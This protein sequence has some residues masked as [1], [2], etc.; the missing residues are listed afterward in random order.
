MSTRITDDGLDRVLAW[1]NDVVEDDGDEAAAHA[2]A[3]RH[4]ELRP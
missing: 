1:L 4:D 3:I 2:C